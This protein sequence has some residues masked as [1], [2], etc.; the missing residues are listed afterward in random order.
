MVL[1][2]VDGTVIG[3]DRV[4]AIRRLFRFGRAAYL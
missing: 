4:E 3:T 2:V 1:R